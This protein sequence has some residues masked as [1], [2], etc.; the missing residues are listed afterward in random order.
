[1][2]KVHSKANP[3]ATGR[4]VS[5]LAFDL[6]LRRTKA[7]LDS[8]PSLNRNSAIDMQFTS[9]GRSTMQSGDINAQSYSRYW[10]PVSQPKPVVRS[11][12]FGVWA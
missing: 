4:K 11:K 12:W 10:T 7:T 1:M 3:E 2:V 8:C 5:G 9:I 6:H